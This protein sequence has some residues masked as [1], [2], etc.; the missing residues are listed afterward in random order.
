LKIIKK[1]KKGKL[2]FGTAKKQRRKT[3]ATNTK[4]DTNCDLR[5]I[6]VQFS[7]VY[8]LNFELILETITF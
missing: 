5:H 4:E 3:Q 7:Y 8:G 6:S 1:M 2:M